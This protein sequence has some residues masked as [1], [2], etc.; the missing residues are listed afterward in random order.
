MSS[1]AS[2]VVAKPLCLERAVHWNSSDG[3]VD[4]ATVTVVFQRTFTTDVSL[5]LSHDQTGVRP[6]EATAASGCGIAPGQVDLPTASHIQTTVSQKTK[7]DL[8]TLTV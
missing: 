6:V 5:H 7:L 2:N 8:L 4:H 3:E 1:P